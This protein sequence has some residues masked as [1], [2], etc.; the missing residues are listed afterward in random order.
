MQALNKRSND[1]TP[2]EEKYAGVT[3]TSLFLNP[4]APPP[5]IESKKPL[6]VSVVIPSWN[7]RESILSCLASIEQSSF[8]I[9]HQN[10]IQVILVDDGSTDGTWEIIKKSRFSLNLTVIRQDHYGQA[11]ALNTGISIAEGDII[12]SCD[13]DMVLCYHTI[14]HFVTRHQLL[15]NVF[16]IGFRS[17]I[18][19]NDPQIDTQ[20]I[21]RHRSPK[22]TYFTGDER[23][24]F[25]VP[26]WPNNMCLTSEHLKL[27]GNAK[28]LWMPDDDTWYLPDFVFGALFSLPRSIYVRVG[29]Y[30]ERFHGWGCTDSFLAAKAIAAGQFIIPIY[31]ASGFHIDHSPRSGSNQQL[32]YKRNRARFLRFL[33]TSQVGNYPN[34]LASAKNRIIELLSFQPT[35]K[36]PKSKKKDLSKLINGDKLSIVDCLLATGEFSRALAVLKNFR[37][38]DKNKEWA[39]RLGKAFLGISRYQEAID[40]QRQAIASSNFSPE[41]IIQ[42]AV[43]LAASGQYQSAHTTLK[44]LSKTHPRTPELSYWYYCSA[45]KH[46]KQGVSYFNQEFYFLALRCF[47]AALIVEPKNKTALKY[48]NQCLERL[49][50]SSI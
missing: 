6:T 45:Q 28:S 2:L 8:N 10:R 16:L 12:I 44:G 18:S 22:G 40:I 23:I 47:E 42:L 14:E 49:S 9:Y 1:Y 17:H 41:P 13:A 38:R 30:D 37:G 21:R 20:Y 33:K 27:L 24:V 35:R 34:W 29:G 50:L 39:M 11:Q 32:E 48:R 26:G 5:K 7:A 15:P 25:P 36:Y 4:F 3:N 31:A 19:K 43:T 46:I